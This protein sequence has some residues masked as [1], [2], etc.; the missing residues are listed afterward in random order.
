MTTENVPSADVEVKPEDVKNAANGAAFG[1]D[2]VEEAKRFE[3]MRE[4][5]E[6][7]RRA[8]ESKTKA[9]NKIVARLN[10]LHFVTA[11]NG[12]TKFCTMQTGEIQPVGFGTPSDFRARYAATYEKW[13]NADGKTAYLSAADIWWPH[14]D[15]REHM[16]GVVTRPG[17]KGAVISDPTVYNLWQRWP[18]VP[19]KGV[20]PKTEA[21]LR[22]IICAGSEEHYRWLLGW[23][24]HSVQRPGDPAEVAVTMRGGRGTGKGTFAAMFG[25]FFGVNYLH[26][27]NPVH[28]TGRF[29]AHLLGKLAVFLDEAFWAGDVKHEGVLKALIT[30]PLVP[31]EAKFVDVI[32]VPNVAKLIMAS[33]NR[34]VVPAASDERRYFMLEV[35]DAKKQDTGYFRELRKAWDGGE[36]AA[37]LHYLLDMDISDFDHRNPPHTVALNEQKIASFDAFDAWWFEALTEG[38][39]GESFGWPDQIDKDDLHR[40]Y[41][42]FAKEHP[43]GRYRLDKGA[44]IQYGLGGKDGVLPGGIRKK[45]VSIGPKRVEVLLLPDLAACRAHFAALKKIPVRELFGAEAEVGQVGQRLDS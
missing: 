45:K 42:R 39:I 15:R 6:A 22:D 35:S 23:M 8:R 3:Q 44:L 5:A 19:A 43:R 41:V 10:K 40:D 34:W 14:P 31:I 30:E 11:I 12:Q 17:P 21:F 38:A 32:N 37:L 4:W 25:S 28:L 7:E 13:E 20:W 27:S 1:E 33:N 26:L 18:V 36:Q 16:G 2:D 9:A 24:A 29:N